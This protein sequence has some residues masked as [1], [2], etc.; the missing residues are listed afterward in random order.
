MTESLDHYRALFVVA[1]LPHAHDRAVGLD[2]VDVSAFDPDGLR[3]RNRNGLDD[4]RRRSHDRRRG[5]DCRR[6]HYRRR[7]YHHRRRSQRIVDKAAHNSADET[8]PEATTAAT[9]AAMV[10]MMPAVVV[11][12]GTAMEA[13]A[14]VMPV[15]TRKCSERQ[16]RHPECNYQFLVHFLVSFQSCSPGTFPRYTKLGG[17]GARF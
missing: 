12:G 7:G 16:G 5:H 4:R 9:P 1:W 8:G 11:D 2:L 14:S 10:M 17:N 3:L 15:G 13:V 6:R